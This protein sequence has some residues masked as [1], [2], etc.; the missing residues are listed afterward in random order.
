MHGEKPRQIALR[1]LQRAA[2]GDFIEHRLAGAL[3][4]N[5][6]SAADRHLCQEL[7]YGVVRWQGTLDWLIARKTDARELK[8]ALRTLLRLGL[9]QIFWLERIPNHAAVHETVELAKQS[10]LH[11]QAGFIN[12]V[13]RGYLRELDATRRLLAELKTQQPHLGHSH[14]EWLAARWQKRWGPDQAAQLMEWNNT[15]PKTFARVNTLKTDAGKLLTQWRDEGVD[16]DFVRRE[17][18]EENLVFE[19]KSHPVLTRLPSFQQGWFYVQDPS[20]LL[21]VRELDPQPGESVLDLCAAPGGKL[22]ALAQ[23]MRNEGR[24][25]AHDTT[26]ERLELIHQN[27]ARLGVSCVQ[28]LLPSSLQS[29][30]AA[31]FDRI[32]LDA[33]CSNTGVMRRRVDLRWRIRPEELARLRA[34]QLQLLRQAAQQLRP[35]GTLV[36]STCSLEPEENTDVL[37]EFLSSH[38]SFKLERTRELLPFVDNVD[39]TYVARLSQGP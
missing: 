7:T 10:R 31:R 26:A 8:P 35:G 15:P 33:P 32:L 20:T 14:P 5:P 11:A 30:P 2:G 1:L 27:C 22:A 23:L 28:T 13:L 18:L 37:N 3:A 9:Y 19:L 25:L 12:A 21:A 39:G 34:V 24:L 29:Q 38:A 6:L 36:Y 17:W 16:Y 4:Q